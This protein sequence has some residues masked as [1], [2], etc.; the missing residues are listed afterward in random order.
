MLGRA[1]ANPGYRSGNILVAHHSE[2]LEAPA[3]LEFTPA[4]TLVREVVI[5]PPPGVQT[6]E[7][8]DLVVDPQGRIHV[9]IGF[10][11]FNGNR[12]LA[13]L[14]SAGAWQF[15][16][17]PNWSLQG[18]TY[19]GAMGVS[20]DYIYAP[21][22]MFGD[23]ETQGIVRFPLEDLDAPEHFPT[24]AFH[25]VKVGLNGLVYGID[26]NGRAE[27][28]HPETME[29]LGRLD[30]GA[31]AIFRGD[32]VVSFA[33]DANGHFYTVD[34]GNDVNHFDGDGTFIEEIDLG[35][36]LSDIDISED[37]DLIVGVVNRKVVMTNRDFATP[38][39][40][41]I[42]QRSPAAGRSF[43][44]F[45]EPVRVPSLITSAPAITRLAFDGDDFE[46]AFPSQT[47]TR[48]S[49]QASGALS[50]WMTIRTGLE[51]TGEVLRFLVPVG[52]GETGRY[53][54]VIC[55]FVSPH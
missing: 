13:T 14:T 24:Q 41:P 12:T 1:D 19:F 18:V 22:Q 54:R 43:V 55:E 2:A 35:F 15:R 23:D 11:G 5:P 49:L 31:G 25:A 9:Q 4:G 16:P 33:V 21:D 45:A 7:A 17:V 40:F 52:A 20:K 27:W 53:Y 46:I 38:C 51:G 47:N 30:I 37:G 26:R 39:E 32:S 42:F 8:R 34:L 28:F 10:S 6:F 48:Y 3:I 29:S 36:G 44:A 50:D